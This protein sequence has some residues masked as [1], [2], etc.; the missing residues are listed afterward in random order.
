MAIDEDVW[1]HSIEE[2]DQ[3]A[4]FWSFKFDEVAIEVQSCWGLTQP[5]AVAGAH[6]S[7]TMVR[8]ES[9]VGVGAVVGNDV[10]F[11]LAEPRVFWRL[12]QGPQKL[13]NRL[14]AGT[15]SRVNVAEQNDA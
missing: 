2:L 10:K 4:C 12:R 1:I 14:F 6:L 9:I 13:Q 3:R 11:G 5:H 7:G 8:A 15:L